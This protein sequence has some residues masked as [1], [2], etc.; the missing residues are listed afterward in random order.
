MTET[1]PDDPP[2]RPALRA[3]GE[4][5]EQLLEAS[6]AAGP[7]ARQRAEELLRVVVE[8]YGGGIERILEL[9]DEAGAL[10]D[11]VLQRLADD[12]LV[13]GLLLVHGL[14]PFGVVERVEQALTRVRPY[15]GS[16]GGDV[17]LLDVTS[18]GVVRLRMLGSCDG[19]PS[20]SITL[21]L[22]VEDAIEAAAPEVVKI[23]VEGA[24]EGA[25]DTPKPSPG[26]VIPVDALTARLHPA[27]PAG[28]A[29]PAAIGLDSTPVW[30]P[31]PAADLPAGSLRHAVVSSMGV[32]LCRLGSDVYAYRD[33]CPSCA[34]NLA[35]G[36]IERRL[37]GSR[38]S[39]VLTCAGCRSHYDVQQ[40]GI[41]LDGTD[42][43]LDPLPLLER[44]GVLQIAVPTPT[45]VSA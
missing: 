31:V 17:E 21:K 39:A 4:R 3:C 5:I 40:A 11:D 18:D 33:R 35:D 2:A 9:V 16:H 10:G 26:N 34:A 37:G 25:A 13:A 8:L 41:G 42:L 7:V 29:G 45:S 19:C 20:S 30:E 1:T 15:L 6:S 43:H 22:A 24:V 14:H 12:E 32:V 23:E 28:P 27:G 44:D 36:A 38:H